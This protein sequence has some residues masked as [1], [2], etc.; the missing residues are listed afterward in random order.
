MNIKNTPIHQRFGNKEVIISEGIRSNNAYV[1]LKGEVRITKKVDKKNIVIGTLKEGEVFGEMGL[2]SDEVRS[3]TV[4]AVGDVTVGIIDK[5]A[6]D[7]LVSKLPED[8]KAIVLALVQRLRVTTNLL[9]RVGLEL[10]NAQNQMNSFTLKDHS[11][12][13]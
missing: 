2:I 5:E 13:K 10:D 1:V 6:F 8:L 3:A 11:K 4:T 7:Q 12:N 9:A